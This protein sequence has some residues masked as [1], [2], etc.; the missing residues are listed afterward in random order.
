M[1]F[2]LY[3]NDV[4][5]YQTGLVLVTVVGFLFGFVLERSGF[6]RATVLS[7]QFYF[8]DMRV[9]K[10][11]FT[12]IA[13]AALGLVIL[14][15]FGVVNLSQLTV[16][17]THLWPVVVGGL[18]LGMG[19]VTSGYCPG[20]SAVASASGNVD[21]I[22][23]LVGIV[24]GS[25]VFGW[26]YPLLEGFY[27]G[28]PMHQILLTETLG[29]PHAVLGAVVLVMAIGA[30][31]GAEKLEQVMARRNDSKPPPGIPAL[32]NRIFFGLGVA[33]VVGLTSM[34]FEPHQATAEPTKKFSTI[35][36]AQL[37]QELISEPQ[38]LTV[39]DLRSPEACAKKTIPGAMCL[40][41]EGVDGKFFAGLKADRTLV[42][43]AEG[44][45]LGPMAAPLAYYRGEVAVLDG[46][47]TGFTRA[48]LEPPQPPENPTAATLEQY[49][50][51]VALNAHF[52]GVKVEHK[53]IEI[54]AVKVERTIKKGG[55]C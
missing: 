33:A 52:T 7:A 21:G 20:T 47:F 28:S 40:P 22:V 4:F 16:P 45:D 5:G 31:L 39:I 19:F 42:G 30:F 25:L 36:P 34:M 43:F 49:N 26:A 41:A 9:L 55:G 32:R 8:T 44:S 17:P 53:P 6:G 50:L 37:A 1:S 14:G 13:T 15:G 10:V 51:L 2:P 3:M 48:I 24:V 54:K 46:G 18:L 38:N 11:M 29:I 23:T 35:E 27:N 12:A